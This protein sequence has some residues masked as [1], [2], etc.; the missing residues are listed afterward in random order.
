MK[1]NVILLTL[2]LCSISISVQAQDIKSILTGIVQSA[3]G[4]NLTTEASIVGTWNYTAPA[5]KLSTGNDDLL[6]TAGNSVAATAAESYLTKVYQKIGLDQCVITF[7]EDGTYTTGMGKVK[8]NG[9]YTFNSQDKSVTF[10]TKLGITFTAKVAV[11]INSMT[12]TFN[13]DKL[14]AAVKAITGYAGNITKY[15]KTINSLLEKYEGISLGF[16]LTKQQQ[17]L[18]L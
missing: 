8:S 12:L 2:M 1:K 4:D 7:N 10:K 14:L 5:C 6:A 18:A 3:V 17:S 11:T 16:Q 9:T 15:A 13:A